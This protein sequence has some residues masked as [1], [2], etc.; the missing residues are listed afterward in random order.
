MKIIDSFDGE[1]FFLSNFS[2]IL[3]V[4]DGRVCR[5]SESAFQMMKTLDP[6]LRDK[7][8]N[9]NPSEAKRLGRRVKLRED[10]EE[11]KDKIMYEIVLSKFSNYE[12]LKK[13]LLD[14]GDAILIEG[15]TWNDTYWGVCNGV[16]EN[17]LG[18]ILMRVREELRKKD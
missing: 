11:V 2:P 7:I 10:W 15:N 17:H 4:F 5:T 6:K 14:T 1:Y 16:G 13:Q 8:A 12:S 3:V 9:A 18:Q